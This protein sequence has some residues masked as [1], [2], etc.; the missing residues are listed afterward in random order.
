M[1]YQKTQFGECLC[2]KH[3]TFFTPPSHTRPPIPAGPTPTTTGPSAPL[4]A[5]VVLPVYVVCFCK[6][7]KTPPVQPTNNPPS[8]R[9]T[10]ASVLFSQAEQTTA[11]GLY[12]V[13]SWM[14]RP[15]RIPHAHASCARGSFSGHNIRPPYLPARRSLAGPEMRRSF[16]KGK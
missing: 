12:V 2:Q 14:R 7:S 9:E 15:A 5:P 4:H 11:S 8:P 1:K 10:N 13:V 6:N 16:R 3:Q